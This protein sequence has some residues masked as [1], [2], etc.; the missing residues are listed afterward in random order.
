MKTNVQSDIKIPKSGF[1]R[2]KF[3]WQHDI[4]TTFGW[5][6]VQ[7]IECK[8]LPPGSK[9]VVN[10][11]TLVRF[12]PMLV[13]TFGRVRYKTYSQFIPLERIFPNLA[14]MLAQEPKTTASATKVA[15]H[16]MNAPLAQISSWC[17]MGARATLYFAI[18]TNDGKTAAQNAAEGNYITWYRQNPEPNS[19][20]QSNWRPYFD[21]L[22]DYSDG[23]FDV[24]DDTFSSNSNGIFPNI[25]AVTMSPYKL[26][27]V[28]A[29]G[30]NANESIRLACQELNDLC[31][32][33]RDYEP[34]PIQGDK[35]VKSYQKEVT[36]DSADF[37]I[38]SFVSNS[39][40]SDRVFFAIA[41][42]FSDFGKRLRKIMQ[43]IGYKINM[44]SSERLSVLPFLAQYLA[45]FD[46]FAV[47]RY[48]SWETTHASKFI[49]YTSNNFTED[50]SYFGPLNKW[51]YYSLTNEHSLQAFM[52]LECA[53]EWYTEKP[54]F[55]SAHT[56]KLAI[57]PQPDKTSFISID[58]AGNV[59]NRAN[60]GI[61][62]TTNSDY[63]EST[64][65]SGNLSV[66]MPYI[67]Q[68][69][70]SQ[71]DATVLQRWA[72]WINKYTPLGRAFDKIMRAFGLGKYLDKVDSNFIGYNDNLLTISDV[73]S[74]AD[75]DRASL[76]EFGGKGLE[77]IESKKEVFEND[78]F[79]Y[80][81]TLACVVPE[82]GYTQSR[83]LTLS[84][85]KKMDLYQADWDAIGMEVTT[86]NALVAEQS[87]SSN[88]SRSVGEVSYGYIPRAS[89]WKVHKNLV[90]G[91]FNRHGL[92]DVYMPFTLDKQLFI[93][94][95]AVD[96]EKYSGNNSDFH[97]FV[98]LNKSVGFVD[99]P[100]AGIWS[101][102]PTKFAWLGNFDRIFSKTGDKDLFERTNTSLMQLVGWSEFNRDNFMCHSISNMTCWAPM[103]P[104]EE[105]YGLDEEESPNQAGVEY[106][107]KA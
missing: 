64:Q 102:C 40:N 89:K 51:Y 68:L 59:V 12:A 11:K 71:V 8:F 20:H 5:G 22:Q 7:P 73:V 97:N 86:K 35:L 90:N 17:F 56:D 92:R 14:S 63:T 10:S 44:T 58:D 27:T 101:R 18:D 4:N 46:V 80:W 52:L 81:I 107:T 88:D 19:T 30:H 75:T 38:E 62:N 15:N 32:V 84:C 79:G 94:D 69:C 23:L 70:H 61:N 54:D 33:R 2:S 37:V 76:G 45:Y 21:K 47:E 105:S 72:R 96:Y 55:W 74:M 78:V 48:Q 104:I 41:F 103:K 6:E 93:N 85:I 42:E 39:D 95:F 28:Y 57:S 87:I 53:D 9:T 65:I 13:P 67:N 91:D 106:V 60:I 29:Y 36:F 34:N 31:P 25:R 100:I 83:D 43:G 50:L 3:N 26:G 66:N 49:Q 77:Y 1:R 16:L 82:A 98:K 99:L 24:E